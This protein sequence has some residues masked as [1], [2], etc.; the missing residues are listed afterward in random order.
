M[1]CGADFGYKADAGESSIATCCGNELA[2]TVDSPAECPACKHVWALEHD[3]GA[4]E[5]VSLA[6]PL[7]RGMLAAAG[8]AALLTMLATVAQLGALHFGIWQ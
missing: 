8:L 3:D 7:V 5:P 6:W 2:V 1:E 4:G